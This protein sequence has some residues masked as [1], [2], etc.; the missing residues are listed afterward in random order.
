MPSNQTITTPSLK[1]KITLRGWVSGSDRQYIQEP[2]NEALEFD[3]ATKA[4]LP[5]KA[6]GVAMSKTQKRS[7]EKYVVSI[8]DVP[9]DLKQA[10]K[11]WDSMSNVDKIYSLPDDETEFVINAVTQED[12]K[13]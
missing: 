5:I 1:L 10:I 8:E 12:S 9:D 11:G 7:V 3:P 4:P 13:K 6:G 2:L